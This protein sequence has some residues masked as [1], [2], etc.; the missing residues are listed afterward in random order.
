MLS[1]V[2]WQAYVV[3]RTLA[4]SCLASLACGFVF[5]ESVLDA[6]ATNVLAA[7]SAQYSHVTNVSCTVRRE[8]AVDEHRGEMVS[9][10]VWA[11]GDKLSVRTLSPETGFTVID[12]KKVW[13]RGGRDKKWTST[14]LSDQSPSQVANMRSIPASP[15]ENLAPLD[16]ATAADIAADGDGVARVVTFK[17]IG[18]AQDGRSAELRIAEDGRMLSLDIFAPGDTRTLLSSTRFLGAFEA[19]PGTWLYRRFE[20][21][22]NSDD[23]RLVIKSRFDDIRVNGFIPT[24]TFDKDSYSSVTHGNRIAPNVESARTGMPSPAKQAIW[25]YRT[26]VGPAIGSRCAL[27]PS[28]SRYF[29]EACDRHGVLGLPMIAD[30]FVREPVASASDKWVQG[31]NGGLKHPDPVSDHDFWM[32]AK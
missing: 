1:G 14:D 8:V 17:F 6:D 2:K 12:G 23:G 30:R 3:R 13:H 10:V 31:S 19:M 32:A 5:G 9:K 21:E 25:F 7:V 16:P 20:T 27:E 24:D 28:C 15:E 22:V 18:E 4:F 26:F 11:R 29:L